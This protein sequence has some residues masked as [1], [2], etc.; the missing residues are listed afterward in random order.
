MKKVISTKSAPAAIGPYSQAIAVESGA[1][2]IY[3]SGQIALDPAT[4]QLVTGGIEAE[5]KQVMRNIEAL[6]KEINASFEQVVKSTIFLKDFNDFAAVNQIYGANFRKDPPA[7]S[8]VEVARLPRDA[9]I[10]IE[11]IVVMAAQ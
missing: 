1:R 6:L 11:C 9:R 5:T 7:R 2:T 3:L 10:E 8:T 4:G